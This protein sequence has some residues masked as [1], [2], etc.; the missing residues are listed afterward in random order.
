MTLSTKVFLSGGPVDP[1][2]LLAWIN[3]NLLDAPDAI[4]SDFDAGVGAPTI[5]NRVGQGLDAWVIITHNNGDP[6]N[7]AQHPRDAVAEIDFDTAY[8]FRGPNGEGCSALHAG[9]IRRLLA[10]YVEPRGLT[11]A[12]QDEF[13]GAIYSGADGLEQF[14]KL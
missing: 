11:L 4:R 10:E 14:G 6:I 2:E 1:E 9:Y 8:G 5:S 7:Y 3:V 13:T 12:W